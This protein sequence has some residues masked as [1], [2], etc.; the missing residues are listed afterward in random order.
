MAL[1]E[2]LNK[3]VSIITN[4]GRNIIGNLKGYD[5][6]INIILEKSHERIYSEDR[7][8]EINELGLHIVRGDNIALIGEIDPEEDSQRNLDEI[9]APRMR[10]IAHS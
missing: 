3:T 10:P 7:G 2:L 1:Q 9:R 8:V 4:D 6:T 5:Q